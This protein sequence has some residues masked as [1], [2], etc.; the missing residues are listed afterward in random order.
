M[1]PSRIKILSFHDRDLFD[2]LD[3]CDDAALDQM[4]FGVIAMD[5]DFIVT[6]YNAEESRFS[7]LPPGKVLGRHFFNDVASCA[8]T[9]A[10]SGRFKSQ[11]NI[12]ADIDYVFSLRMAPVNVRLRL[13][14][15]PASRRMYLLVRKR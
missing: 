14:K 15:R 2:H 13:L 5:R 1:Q 7:G 11:E 8:D 10:V 9:D 6:A 12:D 3:R 4:P